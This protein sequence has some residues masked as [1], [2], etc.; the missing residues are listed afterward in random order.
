MIFRTP[1]AIAI[2][3]TSVFGLMTTDAVAGP[4][5]HRNRDQARR[6][7]HWTA[8]QRYVGHNAVRYAQHSNW[9]SWNGCRGPWTFCGLSHARR[10][11]SR[12]LSRLFVR[13]PYR[14]RRRSVQSADQRLSERTARRQLLKA[15]ILSAAGKAVAE[16][17]LKQPASRNAVPRIDR[18]NKSL[19]RQKQDNAG[20]RR[21]RTGRRYAGR[22]SR[23]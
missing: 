10:G 8:Q 19:S 13:T 9:G 1:F 7:N 16:V 20:R 14:N 6:A 5:V 21:S 15:S 3:V 18:C 22:E 4:V 2:A 23:Y 12:S 11:P 17:S